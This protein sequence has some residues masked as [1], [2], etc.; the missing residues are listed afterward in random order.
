MRVSFHETYLCIRAG[1]RIVQFH[2]RAFGGEFPHVKYKYILLTFSRFLRHL[3][4]NYASLSRVIR[5]PLPPQV[6]YYYI[7]Y[8]RE[9]LVPS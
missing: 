1:E 4:T 7:K 5:A 6:I 9:Y 3:E 8:S 2:P